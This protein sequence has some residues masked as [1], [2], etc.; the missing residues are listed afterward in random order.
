MFFDVFEIN[1]ILI[2][3]DLSD[4]VIGVL[5]VWFFLKVIKINVFLIILNLLFCKI[6]CEVRFE[7]FCCLYEI[8]MILILF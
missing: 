1:I 8:C 6:I 7:V 4:N 3:L 5:G 2:K